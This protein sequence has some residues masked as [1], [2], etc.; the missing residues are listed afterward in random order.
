MNHAALEQAVA[1]FAALTVDVPDKDLERDW[2]W[3]DYDEGV[4]YA[5]FRTYEELRQQ[6][7]VLA[8]RRAASSLPLTTAQRILG[9]YQAAYRDLQAI[10]L[11]VSDEVGAQAPAEGEWSLREVAGH[12]IQAARTFFALIY[13]TIQHTRAG[14]PGPVDV[15]DEEWEALWAGDT[16]EQ[17]RKSTALS[18]L[19][20]YF[21]GLHTR[22]LDELAGISDEELEARSVFWE[23]T[24]MTVHFRLH[25]FD[26][27]LRQHTVQAQKT[28]DMLGQ[29][30]NEARWLLRLI[31][32]ALAEVE[33]ALIGAE[34]IGQEETQALAEGIRARTEEVRRA[35]ATG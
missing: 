33:E 22:V 32:N 7:A 1:G 15:T 11:G 14:D 3:Q 12:A 17:M 23:D 30:P 8:A 26:A 31:Y 20:R 21:E 18:E 25:R 5:F 9:Q 19:M 4:R 6:A 27:H 2:V 29:R 34:E 35:L 13:Y 28:L 16:F 24:P 10:L